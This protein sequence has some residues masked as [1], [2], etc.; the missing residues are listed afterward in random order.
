MHIPEIWEEEKG[1]RYQSNKWLE[2]LK[3]NLEG[4]VEIEDMG[5]GVG[6]SD[7]NCKF[8]LEMY[9]KITGKELDLVNLPEDA[10]E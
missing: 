5:A 6:G 7:I 1:D 2:T 3:N 4:G 10:D 8:V 9:K